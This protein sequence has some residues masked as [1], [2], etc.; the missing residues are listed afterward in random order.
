MA[1]GDAVSL[2]LPYIVTRASLIEGSVDAHGNP[3]ESWG[4]SVTVAVHAWA[5]PSAD[6]APITAGRDPVI[7]DLDLYAPAGTTGQPRD[8]WTVNGV[9]YEQIGHPEDY[10]YGPWQWQAGVRINLKRWEG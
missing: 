1:V 2:P 8:R 10:A 5:P 3:V 4:A 6:S 7:R 9:A